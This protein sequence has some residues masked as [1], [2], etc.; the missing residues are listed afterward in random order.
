MLWRIGPIEDS[1]GHY[2]KG[3][4]QCHFPQRRGFLS[5]NSLVHTFQMANS[6]QIRRVTGFHSYVSRK[7]RI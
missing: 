4:G 6:C 3:E 5:R 2:Q 1:R 7:S